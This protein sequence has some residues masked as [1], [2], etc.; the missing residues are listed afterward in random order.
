LFFYGLLPDDFIEN[1]NRLYTNLNLGITARI[2]VLICKFASSANFRTLANVEQYSI[3]DLNKQHN[4]I[5]SH[6]Y[7]SDCELAGLE[8]KWE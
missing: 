6:S 5:P 8:G 4:K 3:Q 2:E 1:A 7:S